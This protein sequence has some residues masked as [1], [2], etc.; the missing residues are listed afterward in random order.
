MFIKIDT[1]END[2]IQAVQSLIIS[3]PPFKDTI[4]VLEQLPLGDIIICDDKEE[5]LIIERKTLK[6]LA[7]SIKDGRYEEQS[8]RLNGI[9]HPNHNII[10]LIEGS[11]DK[12][13]MFKG[14][15]DKTM[16][17][18]AM[19]SLNYHKGFSVMRS[20]SVEE[21]AFMVCNCALKIA[22]SELQGK[23]PFY[24]NV[25]LETMHTTVESTGACESAGACESE[26]TSISESVNESTISAKDYCHVVKKVKKENVTPENIGEIILSQ[27]PGISSV[28]AIAIMSQ[29]KT[30]PNLIISLKNDT[31]CMQNI[32]YTTSAGQTRKIN[33][34]CI[35]SMIKYLS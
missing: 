30:I 29:F 15:S 12:I 26:S 34:T 10:Y 16:L 35:A 20:A 31:N 19:I 6:D 9:N 18:S 14:N 25:A 33:K 32:S 5:K 23:T 28:T 4:L 22:K 2:L 1:R 11:M 3:S 13:N 21:S 27:I 24:K 8:Y 17:Y 7:S